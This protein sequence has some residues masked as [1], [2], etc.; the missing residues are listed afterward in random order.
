MT[1]LD[2]VHTELQAPRERGMLG[3]IVYRALARFAGASM[4]DVITAMEKTRLKPN[5]RAERLDES[6][7]AAVRHPERISATAD[8]II[9]GVLRHKGRPARCFPFLLERFSN[10][11]RA[12]GVDL[13]LAII[14]IQKLARKYVEETD[15]GE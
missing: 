5:E 4:Q 8:Q 13:A 12:E 6:L 9:I 1:D 14:V 15:H 11:Y 7:S 2:N 3:A 10:D